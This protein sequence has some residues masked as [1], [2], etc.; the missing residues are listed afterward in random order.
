MKDAEHA[1]DVTQ[2]ALVDAKAREAEL[3]KATEASRVQA[4]EAEDRAMIASA[5]MMSLEEERLRTIAL[6]PD[7]LRDEAR[8][9]LHHAKV[10]KVNELQDQIKKLGRLE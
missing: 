5:C 6:S 1:L 7:E 4:G 9:H 10:D 2:H 3:L 8:E